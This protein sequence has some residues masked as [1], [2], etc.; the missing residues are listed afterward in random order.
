MIPGINQKDEGRTAF[1]L[2]VED[3]KIM[4]PERNVLYMHEYIYFEYDEAS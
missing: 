2:L 4:S 3:A 1:E